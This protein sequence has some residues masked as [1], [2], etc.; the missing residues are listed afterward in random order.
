MSKPNPKQTKNNSAQNKQKAAPKK[1]IYPI[2]FAWGLV[3]AAIAFV[4]YANT[5]SHGYCLDDSGAITENRFVHEGFHGIPKL[6]KV[7]F[8]HFSNV[9]LGYY[10]PLALITFAMEQHFVQD[11]PHVSHFINILIFAFS[12]FMLFIVLSKVFNSYNPVF[13]F[14]IALLFVAHPI[15]TEI[16]ANIK[17]RDELLSF[18]NVMIMLWFALKFIDTKKKMHLVLSLISCYFAIP[19]AKTIWLRFCSFTFSEYEATYSGL[20]ASIA[21]VATPR[22]PSSQTVLLFSA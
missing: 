20:P 10:R 17:G 3:I 6:L 5:I 19:A 16:V 2:H 7:D 22:P 4:L 11:N 9:H 21:H 1:I 13:S 14:I 18:L 8:W 15:H 12:G